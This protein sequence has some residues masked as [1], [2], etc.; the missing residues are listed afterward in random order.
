VK[1]GFKM[2]KIFLIA[3]FIVIIL[4]A[5]KFFS[6][7]KI[8]STM[9][10]PDVQGNKHSLLNLK[11]NQYGVIEYL[12]KTPCNGHITA[13]Y[14]CQQTYHALYN[15]PRY[16]IFVIYGDDTSTNAVK[17]AQKY[18]F[19]ILLD[20]GKKFAK[21]YGLKY[22]AVLIFNSDGKIIERHKGGILRRQGDLALLDDILKKKGLLK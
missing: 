19:P 9:T 6:L 2:K 22:Y 7:P 14:T 11:D 3:F 1:Q 13:G 18:D 16:K 21:Q 15:H 20:I 12:S 4:S 17:F 8:P 10:L 5:I